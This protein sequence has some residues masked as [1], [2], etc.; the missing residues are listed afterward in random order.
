M[1]SSPSSPHERNQEPSILVENAKYMVPLNI[2]A[3]KEYISKIYQMANKK[4]LS[5][6]SSTAELSKLVENDFFQFV[7]VGS[8][9]MD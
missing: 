3:K 9:D 2:K 7:E 1:S 8:M 4:K 6:T 5:P